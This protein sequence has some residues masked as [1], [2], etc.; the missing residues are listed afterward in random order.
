VHA[1]D[2]DAA[3]AVVAK[4]AARTPED[5]QQ[6]VSF[7]SLMQ[8]EFQHAHFDANRAGIAGSAADCTVDTVVFHGPSPAPTGIDYKVGFYLSEMSAEIA[9]FTPVFKA[10]KSAP[11]AASNDAM[12]EYERNVTLDSGESIKG[13]I[14]ALKCKCECGTVDK[15]TVNVFNEATSAWAA[16]QKD[17]F[18]K[19]MTRIMPS[20]WP[21]ALQKK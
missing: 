17:E 21:T 6:A 14:Q 16:D 18:Q 10:T 3:A 8:H 2:E 12:F 4:G 5:Q 20:F 1:A 19:A 11:G 9:G 7:A 13:V 15:F